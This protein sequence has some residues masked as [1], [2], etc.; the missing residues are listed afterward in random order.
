MPTYVINATN[1]NGTQQAVY[2]DAA[3]INGTIPS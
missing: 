1:I 2:L 3:G